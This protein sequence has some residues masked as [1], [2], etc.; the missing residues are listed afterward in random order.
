[1]IAIIFLILSVSI[2]LALFALAVFEMMVLIQKTKRNSK[3]ENYMKANFRRIP[4]RVG[5]KQF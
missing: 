2:A 3:S 1:M 4:A 5:S